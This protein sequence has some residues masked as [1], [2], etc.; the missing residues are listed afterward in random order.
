MGSA[1][2]TVAN[3]GQKTGSTG[4]AGTG[5]DIYYLWKKEMYLLISYLEKW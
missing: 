2:R 1:G 5:A 3:D 4:R